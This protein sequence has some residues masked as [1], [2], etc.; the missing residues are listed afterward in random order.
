MSTDAD[1]EVKRLQAKVYELEEERDRLSGALHQLSNEA[2][3][4][5]SE[6]EQGLERAE[7]TIKKLESMVE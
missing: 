1:A 4:K 7:Q 2:L 6:L 3:S 5:I